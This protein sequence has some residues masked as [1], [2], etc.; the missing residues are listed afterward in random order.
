VALLFV[1][2]LMFGLLTVTMGH[3]KRGIL[4]AE[5]AEERRERQGATTDEHGWTR[6]RGDAERQKYRMAKT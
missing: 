5:S 4:T 3:R 1:L 2:F 6:M